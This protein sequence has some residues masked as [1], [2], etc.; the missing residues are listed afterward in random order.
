MSVEPVS[1][2]RV[3][4]QA[5]R[6]DTKSDSCFSKMWEAIKSVFQGIKDF[7]SRLWNGKAQEAYDGHISDYLD[8]N[9]D[10][11]LSRPH[12]FETSY[13]LSHSDSELS[14]HGN[15]MRIARVGGQYLV[16]ASQGQIT[17]M[18]SQQVLRA[19]SNGELPS[20]GR[21]HDGFDDSQGT[22][23]RMWE[24]QRKV[25]RAGSVSSFGSDYDDLSSSSFPV[26]EKRDS[27]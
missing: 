12:S 23:L 27:A 1:I 15:D 10:E 25:D 4:P 5:S 13:I 18:T 24:A 22:P 9:D 8:S 16:G 7:F 21:V 19:L 3:A 11:P 17:R 20:D 14:L 6:T 26:D 2:G